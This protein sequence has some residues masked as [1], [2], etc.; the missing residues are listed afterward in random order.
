MSPSNTYTEGALLVIEVEHKGLT[1]TVVVDPVEEQ[2]HALFTHENLLDMVRAVSG[3]DLMELMQ[4]T[5]KE[6]KDRMMKDVMAQAKNMKL[7]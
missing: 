6:A 4:E 3:A 2:I 7:N 5:I 1:F